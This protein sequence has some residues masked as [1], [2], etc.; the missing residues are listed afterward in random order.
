MELCGA[1]V[2]YNPCTRYARGS[3]CL[4]FDKSKKCDK[5]PLECEMP[6]YDNWYKEV[7]NGKRRCFYP[8][9]VQLFENP[10]VIMF[11]FHIHHH[12]I[13]GE[14]QI[15]RSTLKDGKHFYW[16]DKFLFYPHPVQLELLE[17]DSRLPR[18]A[19]KGR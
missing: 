1:I 3:S 7:V 18:I 4:Y 2:K 11:L 16:F 14:M 6:E 9:R 15:V 19:S 10:G 17:T 5:P 12:A 8:K 13:M